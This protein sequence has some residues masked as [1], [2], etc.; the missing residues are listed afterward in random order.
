MAGTVIVNTVVL[1]FNVGITLEGAKAQVVPVGRLVRSHDNVT[2]LAVP[3]VRVATI[4]V[5]PGFPGVSV[6]PPELKR[7]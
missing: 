7:V 2:L 1:P 6:T 4:G 5:E 3:A